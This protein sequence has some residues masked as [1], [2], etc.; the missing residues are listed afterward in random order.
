[1]TDDAPA[2]PGPGDPAPEHGV[3]AGDG[4]AADETTS[5]RGLLAGLALGVPVMAYG[6]RGAFVD[7]ADTHPA[8]LARW[9]V[10]LALVND[11]VV[12]PLLLAAAWAL[13]RGTPAWAWPTLRAGLTV[14]GTLAL[15]AWPFVRGYGQDPTNPSRLPRD[16]GAGLAAALAA[17]AVATAAALATRAVARRRARSGGGGAPA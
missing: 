10:G 4:H 17:V 12:V 16:Y 2:T 11:V 9:F 1:M 13:R 3:A 8:E 6:V 15:V 14:A 5:R 7:A